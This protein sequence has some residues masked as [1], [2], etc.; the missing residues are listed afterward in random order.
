MG[1]SS[2]AEKA[3]ALTYW[4]KRHVRYVSAGESHD[5]TPHQPAFV[6]A[7][8]FG[9]CKDQTQLL[10]VMLREAGVPV[11]LATLGVLDDGQILDDV[12]SPW[13]THAILLVELPGKG[14]KSE[15]HWIDTTVSHSSWDFLPFS[16]RDRLCYVVTDTGPLRL[17]RTMPLT[18][19]DSGIEQ[20]THIVIGADGSSRCD[21]TVIWHGAMA[22]G[23][24]DDWI[25][26]PPGE[27]RRLLTSSLQDAQ[28]RARLLRLDIDDK[29]LRDLGR[30]V[31][32]H[33]VFEVPDHFTGSPDREGSVN[34]SKLWGRLLSYNVDLDRLIAL[35]LWQ[36]FTSD[37]RFIIDLPPAY[38]LDGRPRKSRRLQNGG[39]FRS[40]SKPIR[41]LRD[42]SNCACKPG[43]RSLGSSQPTW[44]LSASF[45][46]T[47]AAATAFG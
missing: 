46:R 4:V 24:R 1:L 30:P 40:R 29:E 5:Y 45:R 19:D 37:H 14:E 36:P 10:A 11:A 17:V 15:P 41:R 3:R 32:A 2:P 8:R 6:L 16:D 22:L 26:V 18:A 43:W 21:R 42:G 38:E 7:N 25:E 31:T 23:Q 12:P 35:D 44:M 27:R 33:M 28:S 20:T 13:G 39:P 34:D 9:D 47:S